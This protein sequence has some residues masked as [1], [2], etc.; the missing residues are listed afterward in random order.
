M[1]DPLRPDLCCVCWQRPARDDVQLC[2][3]CV[4]ERA[5]WE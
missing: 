5:P 1:T 2:D 4:G 3:G